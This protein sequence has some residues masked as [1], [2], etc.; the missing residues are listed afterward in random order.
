MELSIKR[1]YNFYLFN[2]NNRLSTYITPS[3]HPDMSFVVVV[4]VTFLQVEGAY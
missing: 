3:I 1:L 2:I 4:V